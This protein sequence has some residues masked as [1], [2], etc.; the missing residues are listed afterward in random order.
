MDGIEWTLLVLIPSLE[1][2]STFDEMFSHSKWHDLVS[3][4]V[5]TGQHASLISTEP[6]KIA[7]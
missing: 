5:G 1:R 7:N 3:H 6:E 4:V 2:H